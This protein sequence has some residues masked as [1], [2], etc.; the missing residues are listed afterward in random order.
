MNKQ[1]LDELSQERARVINQEGFTP[2]HDKKHLCGELSDAAVCYCM[3]GYWRYR[4]PVEGIF[5]FDI[6]WFKPTPE[7]RQRELIKAAQFIWAEYD[8]LE[9]LK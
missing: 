6:E 4:L 5:H 7:D 9:S 1:F 8:R 3:R 2:E